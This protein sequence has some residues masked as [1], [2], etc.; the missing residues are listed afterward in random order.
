MTA[1]AV[2]GQSAGATVN[3]RFTFETGCSVITVRA[4][5]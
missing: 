5:R 2:T 4:V 1:V 3:G